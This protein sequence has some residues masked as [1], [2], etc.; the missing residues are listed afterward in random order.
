VNRS[1]LQ[2]SSRNVHFVERNPQIQPVSSRPI[3]RHVHSV[4]FGTKNRRLPVS[5]SRSYALLLSLCL[6]TLEI[7]HGT[8]IAA[9]QN[10]VF[11]IVL[12]PVRSKTGDVTGIQVFQVVQGSLTT[13]SQPFSVVAPIAV[14][15][16]V[17]IADR[18]TNLK[19]SDS[20]GDIALRAEDDP[21]SADGDAYFRHWRA[22]RA[23]TFPV[24]IRYLALVQPAVG[25][26]GPPYGMKATG[27]G[28][29]GAGLGFLALPEKVETTESKLHWDLSELPAGSVGVITA[30]EGDQT[31]S[32]PPSRFEEQWMLAGPAEVFKSQK[33]KFSAYGLGKPAFDLDAAFEWTDQAYDF[34]G[35]SF[36]YLQPI[37][38][39][40][41]MIRAFDYDSYGTGTAF[42]GGPLISVGST[43]S[44][45]QDLAYI[46]TIIFHEMTHQ[47]VG[48][49][50]GEHSWFA[51]GL[52]QYSSTVLPFRAGL[53][54]LDDFAQDVNRITREYYESPARDWSQE[55]IEQIGMSRE[56]VRRTPYDRGELYFANL[57][58]QIRRKSRGQRNLYTLLYPLFV[59]RQKGATFDQAAWERALENELG[60]GAVKEFRGIVL[61]G[62]ETMTPDLDAFGPCLRPHRLTWDNKNGHPVQGYS[63]Q[64]VKNTRTAHCHAGT[65][66]AGVPNHCGR[67]FR[68]R[69]AAICSCAP[70]AFSNFAPQVYSLSTGHT[71]PSLACRREYPDRHLSTGRGSLHMILQRLLYRRQASALLP[72]ASATRHRSRPFGSSRDDR[73]ASETRLKRGVHRPIEDMPNRECRQGKEA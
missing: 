57:D 72:S 16:T 20:S 23:V 25:A 70:S 58:A 24:S 1:F 56:D 43:N 30:G 19:V 65:V 44:D 55:R 39:Y 27:G 17:K 15:G 51:E 28:V 22:A 64:M 37:P 60:P 33:K 7:I 21:E 12:K 40:V 38:S 13:G 66:E 73:V 35:S 71:R 34:L 26:G 62:A 8:S 10:T 63:W 52:T 6:A 48:Q 42:V 14:A 32:G 69:S 67:V 46:H 29:A 45:G 5:L 3:G 36:R 9:Q 50:E 61:E 49:I 11:S 59:S 2:E 31:L 53:S 41:L 47:W 18:I 54:S 4:L 68:S